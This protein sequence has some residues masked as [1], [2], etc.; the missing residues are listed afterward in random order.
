[1][2][3]EREKERKRERERERERESPDAV[4]LVPGVCPAFSGAAR[5]CL[6]RAALESLPQVARKY[7]EEV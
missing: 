6:V 7:E 5:R 3:C 1:M 4:L 2:M